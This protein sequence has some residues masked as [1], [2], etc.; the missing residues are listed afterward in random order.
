MTKFYKLGSLKQHSYSLTAWRP[1]SEIKVSAGCALSSALTSESFLASAQLPVVASSPDILWFAAASL[2][3]VSPSSRGLLP[4][5]S[6][7]LSP[8]SAHRTPV[9]LD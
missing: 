9:I 1:R 5:V 2:Q 6:L 4:C 3:S 7:S 8:F